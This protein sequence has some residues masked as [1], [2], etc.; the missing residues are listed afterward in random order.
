MDALDSLR[1]RV[2][3]LE[4]TM[5]GRAATPAT[6][7]TLDSTGFRVAS[8]DGRYLIR[9]RGYFQSDARFFQDDIRR[10][11]PDAFLLRRVRPVW[12]ATVG[13]R[14][15]FRLMPDFG[16]GRTTLYDAHMDIRLTPSL[17][18]RTGK[19]KPPIGLERLQ[20]A[21][22]LA[23]IERAHPTSLAPN[24]DVGIQVQGALAGPLV[25][26]AIGFFDGVPDIGMG[27]GDQDD[28][29][30]FI[31]RV[32]FTP[33]ASSSLGRRA[34]LGIGIAMSHG[35][36]EGTATSTLLPVYRSP[37]QQAVFVFR[38]DGSPA[39]T[40]VADGTQRRIA[41]QGYFYTGPLGTMVEYTRS[42]YGV[43]RGVEAAALSQSAWQV[44]STLL[45]TGER[46]SYRGILPRRPFD[47]ARGQWGALG[48]CAARDRPHGRRRCLPRIRRSR[49]AGATRHVDRGRAQL[50]PQPRRQAPAQLPHHSLCRRGAHR[51]SRTRARPDD[52]AA[53]QLL[54]GEL[55]VL[56]PR[57]S[58]MCARRAGHRLR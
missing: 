32:F 24:R 26:Y 37:G 46:A 15:D 38:A 51:R 49:H 30:D 50:V 42:N 57:C 39:G 1:L 54:T 23:F 4:R 16:E 35:G 55:N 27:D 56:L 8:G 10:P 12:E 58:G 41:P 14:I 2:Q 21:T 34:E 22:D 20:S 52:Q 18:V 19:F 45:L 5:Q 3:E 53:T 25:T 7:F 17:L 43:R 28:Y 33:L 31:G 13:S 29:K 6:T 36:R 44:T 9:L 40:T 11:A 48:N 47:P